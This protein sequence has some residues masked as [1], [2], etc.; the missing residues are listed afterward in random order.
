[1]P[2]KNKSK[3]KTIPE[4]ISVKLKGKWKRR[5][6][7]F[8]K[9]KGKRNA[10]YAEAERLRTIGWSARVRKFGDTYCVYAG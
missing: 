7:L 2:K 1:M 9:M 4:S 8:S 5:Y 3:K 10:A 6:H